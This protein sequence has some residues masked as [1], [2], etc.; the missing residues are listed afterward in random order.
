MTPVDKLEDTEPDHKQAGAYL[1]LALPFDDCHQHR[2]GKK[3]QE[4][5]EQMA[6]H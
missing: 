6:R 1:Y 4:Y 5:R 3:N 2:E